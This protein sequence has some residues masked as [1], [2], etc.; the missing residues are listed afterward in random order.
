MA[1][2]SPRGLEEHSFVLEMVPRRFW[3]ETLAINGELLRVQEMNYRMES[4]CYGPGTLIA[5][6]YDHTGGR[7]LLLGSRAVSRAPP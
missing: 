1:K 6:L 7:A 4:T 3:S 5:D 2:G